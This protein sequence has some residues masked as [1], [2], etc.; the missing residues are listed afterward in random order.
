MD[1]NHAR[2][3]RHLY[4][5]SRASPS[6]NTHLPII[7]REVNFMI[8]S[9][10]SANNDHQQREN[11]AEQ[12]FCTQKEG[13]IAFLI[14]CNTMRSRGFCGI[15]RCV[16]DAR[17]LSEVVV[18]L[19]GGVQVSVGDDGAASEVPESEGEGVPIST[20][21]T[22]QTRGRKLGGFSNGQGGVW[23]SLHSWEK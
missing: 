11:M 2:P 1:Q 17:L 21:F 23:L 19:P 7:K 10:K 5:L 9:P 16:G 22:A 8:Y 18:V 13:R 3:C 4:I 14:C 6:H 15:I 20:D 12:I